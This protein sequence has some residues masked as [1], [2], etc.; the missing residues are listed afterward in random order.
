M[1]HFCGIEA[2]DICWAIGVILLA[3][4]ILGELHDIRVQMRE[5]NIAIQDAAYNFERI[6][7]A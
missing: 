3:Q 7:R 2:I 6:K 5:L 1:P 4:I